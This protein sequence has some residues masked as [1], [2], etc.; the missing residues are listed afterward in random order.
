MFQ[1]AT[2]NGVGNH[3]RDVEANGQRGPGERKK[4]TAETYRLAVLKALNVHKQGSK[5][6]VENEIKFIGRKNN[7]RTFRQRNAH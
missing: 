6:H 4:A 2:E 5:N 1:I 3:G 7:R